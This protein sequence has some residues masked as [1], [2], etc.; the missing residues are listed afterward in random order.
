MIW[1]K[2][3]QKIRPTDIA[4]ELNVSRAFVSKA[5]RMAEVRIENLLKHV[6]SVNRVKVKHM[7][8]KYGIAVG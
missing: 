4:R 5:L 8:G 2:R 3:R 1:L 6:A 7:S